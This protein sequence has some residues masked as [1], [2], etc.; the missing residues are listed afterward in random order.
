MKL[1]HVVKTRF[2][3]V[4]LIHASQTLTERT[5]DTQLLA[6]R[7][8]VNAVRGLTVNAIWCL[9]VVAERQCFE[10]CQNVLNALKIALTKAVA[11]LVRVKPACPLPKDLV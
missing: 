11:W 7:F 3:W 8:V 5:W 6:R 4:I 10:V 9:T 1:N 2:V